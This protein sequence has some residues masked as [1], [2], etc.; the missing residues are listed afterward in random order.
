MDTLVR[1]GEGL[2]TPKRASDCVEACVYILF[3]VSFVAQIVIAV[4][5]FGAIVWTC[6]RVSLFD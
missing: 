3:R 5:Y 4:A 2:A 6:L 1:L